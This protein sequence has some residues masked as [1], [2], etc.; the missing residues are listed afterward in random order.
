MSESINV[1]LPFNNDFSS[2]KS[3]STSSIALNNN[4]FLTTDNLM[5]D[6]KQALLNFEVESAS[7]PEQSA[8]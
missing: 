6:L 1:V 4:V 7:N 2:P 3:L 5:L 8:K